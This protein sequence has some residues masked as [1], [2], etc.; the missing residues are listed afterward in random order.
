MALT[1]NQKRAV[2]KALWRLIIV[3]VFLVLA[4]WYNKPLAKDLTFDI[5]CQGFVTPV[6][7]TLKLHH[8][9]TDIR[10]VTANGFD[11]AVSNAAS[12]RFAQDSQK[13]LSVLPREFTL[14]RSP[15]QHQTPPHLELT[16]DGAVGKME[17]RADA[18]AIL[19]SSGVPGQPPTL[20]VES[21]RKG[22]V[23]F[24]LV[25]ETAALNGNRY[26][27]PELVPG[28]SL[29]NSFK[30]ATVGAFP[31]VAV[32]LSSGSSPS[33]DPDSRPPAKPSANVTLN[34][35]PGQLPLLPEAVRKP[36]E[37]RL[38]SGS[39][40]TNLVFTGVVNPD[41][42]LK[43]KTVS[44]VMQD[45]KVNLK[46]QADAGSIE[47]ISIDGSPEKR[48]A[49]TLNVKGSVRAGSLRQDGHELLPTVV[50]E[51]L[52]EPYAGRSPLL[53]LLGFAAFGLLK[54]VDQAFSV[55]LENYLPKGN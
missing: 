3:A 54:T 44:G 30:A 38:P 15:D 28:G 11:G 41:L 22:D 34:S 14:A 39:S 6:P 23:R 20:S 32:E 48:H 7:L 16:L 51:V 42:R 9:P 2:W 12:V 45:R 5:V 37:V 50:E 49:P 33:V 24:L 26:L 27:I 55:L 31:G 29:V 46:I 35:N 21:V 1:L 36:D 10:S 19:R 4:L 52:S 17:L 53:V 43:E 25:S 40:P 13:L 8:G 47:T 18:G